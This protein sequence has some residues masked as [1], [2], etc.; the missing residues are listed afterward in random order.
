MKKWRRYIRAALKMGL[1]WALAWFGAGMILVL[2]AGVDAAD[3]PL[4]IAFAGFGFVAGAI[5]STGK[6]E[7]K[8][9][10]EAAEEALGLTEGESSH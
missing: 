1:I 6:V 9:L 4:P 7:E 2:I 10:L 5:L 8:E 3:V